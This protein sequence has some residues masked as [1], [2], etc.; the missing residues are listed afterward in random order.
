MLSKA[1]LEAALAQRRRLFREV[2]V[3]GR[4]PARPPLRP[5]RPS[6]PPPLTRPSPLPA[7][8]PAHIG[9]SRSASVTVAAD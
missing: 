1:A 5:A 8:A 7:S 2:P 6:P 3:A 9:I 4:P